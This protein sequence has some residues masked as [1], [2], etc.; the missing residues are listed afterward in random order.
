MTS[1]CLLPVPSGSHGS[2]TN[3]Q[4]TAIGRR[5]SP[6]RLS[7]PVCE[8]RAVLPD[9]Q[10][11]GDRDVVS[12]ARQAF[13]E[14]DFE[15]ALLLCDADATNDDVSRVEVALLRARILIRLDQA[16]RAVEVLSSKDFEGLDADRRTTASLLLGAAYVRLGQANRGAALL[17]ELMDEAADTHST[18]RAELALNLRYRAVLLGGS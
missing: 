9:R 5:V 10:S 14:G 13:F 7:G 12:E 8:V 6:A 1:C 4:E 17:G 2:A 15:R 11:E 16:D 18:I 3:K